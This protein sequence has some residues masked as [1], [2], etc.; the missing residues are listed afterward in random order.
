MQP[1]IKSGSRVA[2]LGSV[3]A[4]FAALVIGATLASCVSVGALGYVLGSSGLIEASKFGLQSVVNSEAKQVSAYDR[5]ASQTLSELSSNSAIG[6]AMDTI[7]NTIKIEEDQIRAT[8]QPQG[9]SPKQRMAISGAGAKLLFGI[10]HAKIHPTLSAALTNSQLS[11]I[12]VAGLDGVLYYTVT[13]GP[14]FLT[15]MTDPINAN[16]KPYFDKAI[17]GDLDAVYKTGFMK[18]PDGSL[19]AYYIRPLAVDVWGTKTL[20]GVVFVKIDQSALAGIMKPEGDDLKVDNA[21]I[22]SQDGSLLAG[23][24]TAAADGKAPALLQKALQSK[25]TGSGF[26][27]TADGSMF[28]AFKPI[29]IDGQPHLLAVGQPESLILAAAHNLAVMAALFGLVVLAVMGAIG[30]VISSRLTRPL[31]VLAELMNRLNGGE[32]TIQ[33]GYTNRRDEIGVMARSLESFRQSALDK[34]RMEM[35]SAE[36]SRMSDR[37]RQEREAEKA[38]ST[39]ELEAA[40]SAL[41]AALKALA[42]GRLETRIE[43]PFVATLDQLRVD[44]NESVERLEQTVTAIGASADAIQAGSADLKSASENLAHRTERQAASLEE[45]AAALSEMTETVNSTVRRCETADTVASSAL[46]N[47][48]SSGAVVKEAISA[49][50]RIESSSGQI[51][52]IID[53]IDQIAFQTNLLALNAGVEAARAGDAGKGFAVVAQE[54]REL[55]QKSAA[56]AR[57][58]SDIIA[59]SANDVEN[60]VGLVLKTGKSLDMIEESVKSI[61]EHIGEIVS[62]SRDQSSRLSEINS[63]VNDLDHVTQ[64]NAAMVEE[65]TAAAFSLDRESSLLSEQVGAFS[66]TRTASGRTRAA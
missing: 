26:G 58:I 39:A 55:A 66:T 50:E 56:A 48:L 23:K 54:V 8:F 64:Q 52:S 45:A 32:K 30:F 43:R 22:L 40:V 38:R 20:K 11:E 3:K 36:Q 2:A 59:T 21:F 61:H 12:Y 60:G 14:E 51:R 31:V 17:K 18:S 10:Q 65:T 7:P 42:A 19:A 9:S 34:D 57:D 62:A 27:D 47:T 16:L 5:R 28:Y 13:K 63:T 4:K 33:V 29:E 49:M 46:D 44:F 6:E 37:D 1:S 15:K 25:T 35:E 24:M 41:A 53:V